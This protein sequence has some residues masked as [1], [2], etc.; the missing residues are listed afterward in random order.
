[1]ERCLEAGPTAAGAAG[2]EEWT[3]AAAEAAGGW[4]WLPK[5]LS[6]VGERAAAA[7]A[8]AKG[9]GFGPGGLWGEV[10]EP[11][12][13]HPGHRAPGLLDCTCTRVCSW[14]CVCLYAF[15]KA[16]LV[17]AVRKL[18]CLYVY[19]CTCDREQA[20]S[21]QWGPGANKCLGGM[22]MHVIV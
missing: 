5:G 17:R 4:G 2:K 6:R 7:R 16:P 9:R 12:E 11:A 19:A 15:L 8:A 13:E 20:H 21:A 18:R 3:P 22:C 14:A 1:M 10:G